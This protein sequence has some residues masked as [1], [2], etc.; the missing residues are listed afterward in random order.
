MIPPGGRKRPAGVG[1]FSLINSRQILRMKMRTNFEGYAANGRPRRGTGWARGGRV[2]LMI[3]VMA[4][5]VVSCSKPAAQMAPPVPEVATVKVGTQAVPLA[6]ELPGRTAPFLI[7]EIRPQVNGLILRRLF[8]EGTDV[9]K[10]QPLYQVDPAPFEAA[11]AN[12]Q[13]ALGRSEA[14]LPAV[15]ARLK[16]YEEALTDKA[17]SQQDYD[18]ASAALRQAEAD[19]QYYRAMVETAKINLRY[20]LV[21]SPIAGRIGTSSV[22]DGAIVTAYQPLPLATVQQLD[23]IYVDVPQSTTD[24]LKLKRLLEGGRL[25]RSGKDQSEVELLLPDGTRYGRR[26]TMQFRDISVDPSTASVILRMVFPNP[27]GVLLPGMFVRAVVPEG[28]N[29]TGILIPQQTVSRDPKGKPYALAV[30]DESKVQMRALVLDRAIGN[31]WLVSSGL[32]PGERVVAEGMQKVRP[33]AK[34]KEVPFAEGEGK[35]GGATR[36]AGSAQH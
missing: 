24:L 22:T 17:V 13:A 16:R 18:D 1:K 23:P 29:E 25:S 4:G 10:D 27:D 2:A 20:A 32:T 28:V 21:V 35:G 8:E 12:A 36:A 33:G 15:R 5:L 34:V 11:L 6:I 30:D 14:S 31:Q 7:A 26:G 3:P 9:K 19:A